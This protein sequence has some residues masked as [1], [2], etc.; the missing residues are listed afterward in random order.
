MYLPGPF[1]M[2]AGQAGLLVDVTCCVH[3]CSLNAVGYSQMAGWQEFFARFG[4]AV[5][6]DNIQH[7]LGY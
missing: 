1:Q 4:Q 3:L 6:S 2:P 7:L 5:S